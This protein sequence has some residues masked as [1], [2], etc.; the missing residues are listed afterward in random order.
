MPNIIFSQKLE[1]AK[2]LSSDEAVPFLYQFIHLLRIN[3]NDPK[4]ELKEGLAN[5]IFG[6]VI[7]STAHIKLRVGDKVPLIYIEPKN[8]VKL[9]DTFLLGLIRDFLRLN[10]LDPNICIIIYPSATY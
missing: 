8:E 1:K 7:M 10:D 9:D 4:I 3:G 2:S 6:C 5:V